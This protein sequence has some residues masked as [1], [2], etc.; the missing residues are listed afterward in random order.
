MRSSATSTVILCTLYEILFHY[1][2]VCSAKP[3]C[4]FVTKGDVWWK[5]RH[6]KALT[7]ASARDSAVRQVLQLGDFSGSGALQQ[8]NYL[9][10]NC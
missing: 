6:L 2:V 3:I 7:E 8:S 9:K 5:R 10:L 4:V 1:A